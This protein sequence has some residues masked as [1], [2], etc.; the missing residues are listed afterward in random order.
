MAPALASWRALELLGSRSA[1]AAV[2]KVP[3]L[4]DND[5]DA[6]IDVEGCQMRLLHFLVALT[7]L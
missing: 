2:K 7:V 5:V 6:T 1:R 4:E 3:V